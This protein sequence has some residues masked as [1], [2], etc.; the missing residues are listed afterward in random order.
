MRSR[1]SAVAPSR[2]PNAGRS[3]QVNP[4][5]YILSLLVGGLGTTMLVPLLVEW[6]QKNPLALA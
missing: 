2:D 4:V 3:G 6:S 1:F 5:V